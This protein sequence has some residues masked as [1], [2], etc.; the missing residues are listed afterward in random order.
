MMDL[1]ERNFQFLADETGFNSLSYF[2][3]SFKQYKG[4]TPRDYVKNISK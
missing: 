3:T 4:I 1:G 2:S